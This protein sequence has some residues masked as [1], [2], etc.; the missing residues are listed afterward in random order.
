MLIIFR[1]TFRLFVL[2]IFSILIPFFLFL[3]IARA[4]SFIKV[5]DGDSLS[6]YKT[7][8]KK[9]LRLYGIDSPELS[10]PIGLLAKRATEFLVEHGNIVVKNMG[11]DI[12]GRTLAIIYLD[13]GLTL[14][15][16]LLRKGL[17][18]VYPKYCSDVMCNYWYELEEFSRKNKFGLWSKKRAIPPWKWRKLKLRY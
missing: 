17:A 8:N 4:E 18:W 14:Q 6:L 11:Y 12:Y 1:L 15:E 2:T 13:D 5:I 16:H 7:G 10:Q 9:I 3:C